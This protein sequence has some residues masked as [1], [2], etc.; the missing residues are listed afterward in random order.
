[1]DGTKMRKEFDMTL[2]YDHG[3]YARFFHLSSVL[4]IASDG[5]G[6]VYYTPLSELRGA[7]DKET[8][9][10]AKIDRVRQ[11]SMH[12]LYEHIAHKNSANT[13]INTYI[14][15]RGV[16]DAKILHSWHDDSDKVKRWADDFVKSIAYKQL[17]EFNLELNSFVVC[18]LPVETTTSKM[19]ERAVIDGFRIHH[20][21]ECFHTDKLYKKAILTDREALA[22]IP[23]SAVTQELLELADY[24]WGG[25]YGDRL[26]PKE[27]ICID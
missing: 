19:W 7:A 1:M 5:F 3:L 21:P 11:L 16:V 23:K 27:L 12:K 14:I 13:K 25:K 6:N 2:E 8:T 26:I 17:I 18:M 9:I 22:R 24:T 15:R 4:S 20:V 10:T